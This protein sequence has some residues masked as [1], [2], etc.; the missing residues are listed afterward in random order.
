MYCRTS[1]F[2]YGLLGEIVSYHCADNHIEQI[3]VCVTA[4]Q[5]PL[6]CVLLKDY[7][8]IDEI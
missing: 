7:P 5:Q 6:L 1:D 8:S 3:F 4:Q 2:S